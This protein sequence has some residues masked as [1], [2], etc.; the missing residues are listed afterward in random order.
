MTPELPLD[1]LRAHRGPVIAPTD[2]AYDTARESFNALVDARP[3]VVVRPTGTEDVRAAIDFARTMELPVSI[4]GGGHSVAGHSVGDGSVMIDLRLLRDVSVDRQRRLVEV[5]GGCCWNDVDSRTQS[6][7]LAMPGGTFGD[8]GVAGLTLNGGIGH[9]IGAFG[10]TLDNLE[11][12]EV[13]AADGRIVD[14]T[15]QSKPE[16]FWALRGGGGNFGVVTSFTFRLQEVFLMTGGVLVHSLDDAEHVLAAFRDLREEL[17]DSVTC[18]PALTSSSGR[19]DEPR[20]LL[21][22]IAGLGSLSEVAKTIAPLR[23]RKPLLDTVSPMFYSQIQGLYGYMPFG[24]RNYWTGRFLT[25]LDDDLIRFLVEHFAR[26][27]E[28]GEATVL[29]EP[30]H[31]AASRVPT[32]DTAFAFRHARFNVSGLA[33]WDDPEGDSHAIEWAAAVRDRL[34]PL[35][36]GSYLNYVS[37]TEAD[38]TE[39]AYGAG[40]F[41]RLQ[42]VK[43][44]WDPDNIFRFNHNISPGVVA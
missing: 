32:D 22:T 33:H 26:G 13:V 15:A 10:L 44:A 27:S 19:V 11:A 23:A 36:A 9:L 17:P 39:D 6:F 3:K 12:A 24:M 2:S 21:T 41:A 4:R 30:F 8:T 31:G 5:G 37:D 42:A 29:I 38:T 25:D 14:V 16:L 20:V 34:R 35:S 43:T 7:E 18:I 1:G 40:V 28:P